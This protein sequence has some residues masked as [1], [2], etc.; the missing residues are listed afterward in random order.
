MKR[1]TLFTMLAALLLAGSTMAQPGHGRRGGNCDGSGM[2]QGRGHGMMGQ[3]QRPGVQ[4]LLMLADELELTDQQKA[5]L[6]A[7][8]EP[9]QTEKIDLEASLKK[10]KL[11]M[12][13]L[14]TDEKPNDAKVLAAIDQ[15]TKLEGDMKKMRYR[16]HSEVFAM[17]T[18]AQQ[19]KLRELR[20]EH[21]GQGRRMMKRDGSGPGMGMGMGMGMM[22][23]CGMMPCAG[24]GP[25]QGMGPGFGMIND[26]INDQID[27]AQTDARMQRIEE[28]LGEDI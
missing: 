6:K 3:M 4:R 24:Q 26:R 16:H 7:K 15:V 22:P 9:F 19:V 23:G 13:T 8:L 27:D 18:E 10:A 1:T 2:G 20:K 12:R 28:I 5:D 21:M 25:C 17:L 11:H 14:M